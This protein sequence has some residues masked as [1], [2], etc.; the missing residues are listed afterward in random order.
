MAFNA[1]DYTQYYNEANKKL[2]AYYQRLL[3][4]EGGDVERVK[5]RLEEDYAKGIRISEEDYATGVRVTD[6]DYN[7]EMRISGEDYSRGMLSA[8]EQYLA[9]LKAQGMENTQEARVLEGNLLAR[10]VS[11]GGLASQA[12]GEMK[13]RQELR[14]EAIDRALRKSEEDL[15]YGKERSQEISGIAQERSLEA[16]GTGKERSQEDL[17]TTK[18]RGGEDVLSGWNKYQTQMAQ[19]REEKALGIAD[20]QYNRE[21]SKRS[22]EESFKLAEES[23]KASRDA[24]NWQKEQAKQN[25]EIT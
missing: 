5:R 21:F 24:M 8:E 23:A 6:Q 9:D 18:L 1:P 19:E 7:R 20:S 15:T 14:R 10:G 11:Q 4:E 16:L 22:A 12:T 2:E 25:E 3:D 17:S 13:S